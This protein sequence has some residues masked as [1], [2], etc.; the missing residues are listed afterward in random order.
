MCGLGFSS[1]GGLVSEWLGFCVTFW[2]CGLVTGL[3][4]FCELMW[5]GII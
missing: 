3:P 2:V 5:V 1:L 4:G